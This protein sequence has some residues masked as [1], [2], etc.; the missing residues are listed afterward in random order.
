MR[1]NENTVGNEQTPLKK[2]EHLLIA[3]LHGEYRHL[4][5][6]ERK[7]KDKVYKPIANLVLGYRYQKLPRQL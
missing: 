3:P 5:E 1:T 2:E 4:R 7:V 6:S